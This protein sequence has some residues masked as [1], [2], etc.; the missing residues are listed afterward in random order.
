MVP[1]EPLPVVTPEAPQPR[2][3]RSLLARQFF[4]AG[5]TDITVTYTPT[6][7]DPTVYHLYVAR[8]LPIVSLIV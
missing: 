3:A 4:G 2:G 8:P 1:Q 7:G 5:E 6:S